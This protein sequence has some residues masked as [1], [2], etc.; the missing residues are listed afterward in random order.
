MNNDESVNRIAEIVKILSIVIGLSGIIVSFMLLEEVNGL[1]FI[2]SV[3]SIIVA[4]FMYA[5]GEIIGLLQRI[6]DNTEGK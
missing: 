4:I 5:F 3:I 1:F 6:S 2:N